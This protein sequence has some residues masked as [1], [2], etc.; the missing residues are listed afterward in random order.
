M[1]FLVPSAQYTNEHRL[2]CR[3][4]PILCVLHS[5]MGY[6]AIGQCPTTLLQCRP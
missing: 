3:K 1:L 2:A 5:R 6:A 4:A